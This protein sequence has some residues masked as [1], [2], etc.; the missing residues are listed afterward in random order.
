MLAIAPAGPELRIGAGGEPD[1]ASDGGGDFVI[2]W[3]RDHGDGSGSSVFGRQYQSDGTPAAGEFRV[4]TTIVGGNNSP[5]V[6]ADADGDFVVVWHRT[7]PGEGSGIF[8]Q[9]YGAAGGTIDAEFRINAVTERDERNPS[10]AMDS[11][12]NFAVAWISYQQDGRE[13][14][15]RA[16]RY[17]HTGAPVGGELI[18]T[19]DPVHRRRDP[20]IAMDSDGDFVVVWD[21]YQQDGSGLGV[22]AQRYNAAGARLAGEFRVNTTTDENQWYPSV[23]ADADGDFV[24]A[25]HSRVGG[26]SYDIYAQR[27]SA[28]GQ[29]IGGEFR[30]NATIENDQFY[31]S[32]S[33]DADGDF[34]VSWNTASID[35]GAAVYARAYSAAGQPIGGEVRV[36]TTSDGDQW[37]PSVAMDGD[38]DFIIAWKGV[39]AQRYD[40]FADPASVGDFIWNDRNGNGVQDNGEPGMDGVEVNLFD[41]LGRR[42]DSTVS[43]D[44]GRYRFD[45]LRP[46]DSYTLQIV[47][48]TGFISVEADQGV[49]DS[50]DSDVRPHTG[51]TPPFTLASNEVV[52]GYDA[53]L[54]LPATVSGMKFNDRDRDGLRDA[55]EGGLSGWII[56][57][58]ADADGVLDPEEPSAT[59]DAIGEYRLTGLRSGVLWIAELEQNGWVRTA[60]A[61]GFHGVTLTPGRYVTDIDFGAD[62]DVPRTTVEPAGPAFSVATPLPGH[63]AS[64]ATVAVDADGDFVVVWARGDPATSSRVIYARGYSASGQPRGGEF[65][66]AAGG[67]IRPSLA[68]AAGGEFVVAWTDGTGQHVYARRYGADG[69]ALGD[70]FQVAT[71][72]PGAVGS[73]D[74][75]MDA[76]GDFVITWGGSMYQSNSGIV[77]RRYDAAGQPQGAEFTVSADGRVFEPA[78][79]MDAD[80]DFVVAWRRLF[81]FA[82]D[83]GVYARRYTAA[84]D[85]LGGDF[86]VSGGI[87]DRRAPSV[88]MDADGDFVVGWGGYRKGDSGGGIYGRRYSADGQALGAV[89]RANTSALDFLSS[90]SIAAD[91]EGDFVI[92]WSG[93]LVGGANASST[94]AR[95]FNSVGQPLGEEFRVNTTTAGGY[96]AAVA[97]DPDGD[98]VV[99]WQT[100]DG[101][102]ARPYTAAGQPL[103]A[104]SSVAAN[105][106]V[107]HSAPVAAADAAGNFVVTW[108]SQGRDGSGYSIHAQR[109]S[110]TGAALGG[111]FRVSSTATHHQESPAIAMDADGDF[112]IAW[113]SS[114]QD[115]SAEGIYAQRFGAAGAR[116]GD[117][118]RVNG[119]TAGPQL[120]PSIAMDADGDFVVAWQSYGHD[121]SGW[122]AYAR[123]YGAAGE[124][125]G[126][127][128]RV[129]VA[130]DG[131]Q[132]SPAVAADAEGNF[133][134]AWLSTDRLYGRAYWDAAGTLYA[135]R[136]NA[137]GEPLGAEFL[138]DPAANNQQHPASIAMDAEGDF[139]VAWTSTVIPTDCFLCSASYLLQARRFNSAGQPQGAAFTVKDLGR[140]G[141]APSSVAM[142]ADGSFVVTWE[143][144]ILAN[145][146]PGFVDHTYAQYYDAAGVARGPVL[147]VVGG[148]LASVAMDADGDFVVTWEGGEIAVERY[149][150]RPLAPPPLPTH[151]FVSST[152]WTDAFRQAL[153]TQA[154]GEAAYG[155]EI[156]GG[157]EQLNEL[158]WNNIDRVS[159]RFD[160]PLAP[161]SLGDLMVRGLS[162]GVEHY[163]GGFLGYDAATRTATFSL[164]EEGDPERPVRADRLRLYLDSIVGLTGQPVRLNVLPGDVNRSGA[165]L[166]DDFSAVKRKFFS[167][168]TNPGAGDAAYSVFHDIDGSG[169]ILADDFSAVL[170]R[171]FDTLPSGNPA[172]AP[173]AA[174]WPATRTRTRGAT[175]D[176]FGSAPVVG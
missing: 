129:N 151:L 37:Y 164:I 144:A 31:P 100:G 38:G 96:E 94:Y 47:P 79:A 6:A 49:D 175:G 115:G 10:V 140:R 45:T 101:V 74:V 8:A 113:Q 73:A 145:P 167:S 21:S 147:E 68:M 48:P 54:V 60:P 148:G 174:V 65:Q 123:R 3:T 71:T 125:R 25:W 75:A 55:V 130:T 121:G 124:P 27:F 33:T 59:T 18:V 83:Q 85:P 46:G 29:V 143:I 30:V 80:G 40:A 114:E 9:R 132:F 88:A 107:S 63:T 163:D 24:V 16:Q 116:L 176:L 173:G 56:Y 86:F 137:A 150:V 14:I 162:P 17:S 23:A 120:F 131:D 93:V 34:V 50:A 2:V 89:F 92:V 133:L 58:D 110:A 82:S 1:L 118:F 126:E 95:R 99:I 42:V 22:Y 66:I 154:L 70:R 170:R 122:G 43:A 57:H 109:Y 127:E 102:F 51:R 149:D 166:A 128:F 64:D 19:P 135:R 165:V 152:R 12:G 90:W 28:A 91:G 11:D 61:G 155:Y 119:A 159:V 153:A 36:N 69:L 53:G 87:A 139:V 41:A 15:V 76:D 136:Y 105:A 168:T 78:I 62:T 104:E 13:S 146:G 5:V 161:E 72:P 44:G 169:S 35:S 32:V 112:V 4:N 103:G 142:A 97:A 39:F 84:G 172:A 138:V 171:F 52:L 111:E 7:A 26:A 108:Q 141:P 77:A 160:R 67:W 20:S 157:A 134:V 156:P 158:P 98:F 81:G 117:E 106:G